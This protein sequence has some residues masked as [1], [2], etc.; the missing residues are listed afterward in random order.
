MNKYCA[1]LEA[2]NLIGR[3]C[4]TTNLRETQKSFNNEALMVCLK[5]E[6]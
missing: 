2:T 3:V 5:I 1:M 4:V 6:K